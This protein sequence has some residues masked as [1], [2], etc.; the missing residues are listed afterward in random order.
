MWVQSCSLAI[1][2]AAQWVHD[3]DVVSACT[4]TRSVPPPWPRVSRDPGTRSAQTR[5]H[6]SYRPPSSRTNVVRRW[7]C[8]SAHT[9]DFR[10]DT[11]MRT[12]Q[13]RSMRFRPKTSFSTT[14]G[15]CN[16]LR[17]IEIL[18]SFDPRARTDDAVARPGS[19]CGRKKR[20]GLNAYWLS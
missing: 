14:I 1:E 2:Q 12:H 11:C 10:N 6:I 5:W 15:L 7:T 4:R 19:S 13:H 16:I 18:K 9:Q 3:D 20:R 17:Q 8:R